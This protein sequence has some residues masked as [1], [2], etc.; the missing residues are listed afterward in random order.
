MA[1]NFLI[2]ASPH[3]KSKETVRR[4]MWAVVLAL[5]PSGI[6]GVYIFGMRSL[7]VIA[8]CIASA[9]LT[10]A[11]IQKLTKRPVAISNGS[12]I[13][14]GLLLAYNLPP[15]IPLWMPAIGAVFAVTIAKQAFGGL[16]R[17][18]FNPALAGRAFLMA[19]WPR[20]M[21]SWTNPRW[22][23]DG[24][25]TATPLAAAK[26]GL[27]GHTLPSYWN[28]FLGNRGGCIGEVCV[29]ALLVGAAFLLWKKYIR[30]QTPFIYI[31]TVGLLTWMFGA[32]SLFSGDW[33]FAILSGGLILGAFFMATDMVTT[34]IT[35]RGMVI[36]GIGC[37][38]LTFCIRKW[39]GYPE[40]VSYSILMMNAATP[41]IDRLTRP[42]VFGG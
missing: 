15:D 10:E 41:L 26:E 3:V 33:L 19:S 17:N 32:G 30:W 22:W 9:A 24:V 14:T 11:L 34:P 2:S 7:Y 29:I 35:R 20:Q 6:A 18:I 4:I 39:G 40:G 5:I 1:D 36:F 13:I 28:L 23:P 12:V 31:F 21:T 16:G 8:T 38:I 37:G 27:A 25:S 42:K